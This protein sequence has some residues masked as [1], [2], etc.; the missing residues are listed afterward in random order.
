MGSIVLGN[1]TKLYENAGGKVQALDNLNL[2]VED[3]EFL[4][5][6]GP[7]GSGKTTILRVIA[8][9]E[10][11]SSGTISIDGKIVN[12]VAPKERDVAMVFQHYALYPHMSVYQNMAFGLQLRKF[13]KAEI[14]K[15]VIEA[16]R[17]LGLED[18]LDRRP[19]ALSGGQRQRVALGRAIVRQPKVCLL[20][21]PLSNLDSVMR[22]QVRTEIA[23]L[24]TRLAMTMLYVTHD[25]QEA[26]ALGDRIV[27]IKD[28]IVQQVGAPM[29][30]YGRPENIFVAGF[31]GSPPMN[32][33]GGSIVP[34]GDALFFE[35]STDSNKT[36]SDRI[37][38]PLSQES[39]QRM[40]A[41]V[42][43][44]IVLGI[45][46]ENIQQSGGVRAEASENMMEAEV[47]LVEPL[48]PCVDLYL[49]RAGHSFTARVPGNSRVRVDQ[50]V[51]II[52]A[53]DQ[54]HFFDAVTG[55][56]IG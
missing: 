44:K 17:V 42:G 46:P 9:L 19:E 3:G 5:I 10:R 48:G 2:T 29:E 27:V 32:F 25:Q 6:V 45:R 55:K 34:K 40:H 24:H 13:P 49:R 14:E 37:T 36:S 35:P 7:S 26:L 30:I 53:M 39:S 16:A 20:D 4:V 43:S 31:I 28:G 18:C 8:G 22:V 15:R 41:L 56:R 50:R 54:A 47:D 33:F 23:K 21:E 38:L 11:V 52:F 1:I 51:S 12:N